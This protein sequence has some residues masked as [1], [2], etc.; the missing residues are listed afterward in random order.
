MATVNKSSSIIA[1]LNNEIVEKERSISDI[2]RITGISKQNLSRI[3]KGKDIKISQLILV[4]DA[5]GYPF[6]YFIINWY[7]VFY[8]TN[9]QLYGE[10]EV[11]AIKGKIKNLEVLLK[12]KDE[13][14]SMMKEV[15]ARDNKIINLQEA[16]IEKNNMLIHNSD[17]I[18]TIV[19]ILTKIKITEVNNSETPD[20]N[21][22]ETSSETMEKLTYMKNMM[23][24]YR[25]EHHPS[26]E[27]HS[28]TGI[29]K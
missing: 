15:T 28:Q 1:F 8:E 11:A 13:M 7:N 26:D 29:K 19:D 12:E 23:K 27:K 18:D 20:E 21:N 22:L 25:E 24:A 17:V 5:I 14:I 10:N 16:I 4:L 9:A 3:L 2:A 6:E